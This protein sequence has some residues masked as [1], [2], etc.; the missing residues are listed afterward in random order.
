MSRDSFTAFVER[1]EV[2]WELAMGALA[3]IWVALGFLIDQLGEGLRPDLEAAEMVLTGVFIVEFGSRLFAAHD[4][5][6]YV[7]GHLIDALALVPPVR[8]LRVLRLL[9][10]LRLIRAFAGFY[11]VAM[12]LQGIARH[13]GFAWLVVAWLSVMALT[14]AFVYLAEHG[15]NNLY[16]SPFDALWWGVSTLTTVGYGDT[17]P[18]TPEG[19]LGAMVLMVL[20]IGLFSAITAS[21]TSYFVSHSE[22]SAGSR[23]SL[24]E[25]LRG[26]ADLRSDGAL[27]EEEFKSAKQSLLRIARPRAVV[28]ST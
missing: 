20:G 14:S 11:R 4:R 23:R 8:A 17:V 3:L 7:R 21:I 2:A 22:G 18:V 24:P 26:L 5:L 10:L 16:E 25:E 19:R 6:Q 27:T 15:V 9:R 13:R 28:E 12:H 1:H